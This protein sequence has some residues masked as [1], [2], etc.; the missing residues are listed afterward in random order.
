MA[1]WAY[2]LMTFAALAGWAGAQNPAQPAL[3]P[4]DKLRLLR[5]NSALIDDLV[6]DG[7][8]LAVANDP[9]ARADG[10]RNASRSLVNAIEQAA[11]SEDAERVAELTGLF[12][13]VVRD[14]LVPTM[15]EAQETVPPQSKGGQRLRELRGL[16]DKDLE[17]LTTKLAG[18]NLRANPRVQEEL[19]Q[20]KQLTEALKEPKK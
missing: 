2:L 18:G 7:L 4:E 9:V 14:G 19:K 11:R 17:G 3:S 20:L 5:T 8:K 12:R 13:E 15:R 10:A 1:R 16:A 6:R